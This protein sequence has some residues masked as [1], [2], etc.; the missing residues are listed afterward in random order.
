MNVFDTHNKIIRDYASYIRSFLRI[1]DRQ[2]AHWFP[3]CHESDKRTNGRRFTRAVGR[4]RPQIAAVVTSRALEGG[5]R[6]SGGS[7]LAS[8]RLHCATESE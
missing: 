1:S 5:S 6:V 7:K 8:T 4:C 3:R 2:M